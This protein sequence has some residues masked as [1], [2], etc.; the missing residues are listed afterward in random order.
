MTVI[1]DN[2]RSDVAA[3]A[4]AGAGVAAGRAPPVLASRRIRGGGSGRRRDRVG[5]LLY[6]SC[7]SSFWKRPARLTLVHAN[8]WSLPGCIQVE[9][10]FC[11]AV[12]NGIPL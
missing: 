11:L 6:P 1:F 2:P 7:L 5:L 3:V 12:P 9:H 4:L 10:R 8:I